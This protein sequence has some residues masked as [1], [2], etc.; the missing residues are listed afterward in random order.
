MRSMRFEDYVVARDDNGQQL[1]EQGILRR[2]GRAL[3]LGGRTTAQSAAAARKQ[4]NIE[5]GAENI[6]GMEKAKSAAAD[7][8]KEQ[9]AADFKTIKTAQDEITAIVDDIAMLP[10]TL[11]KQAEGRRDQAVEKIQQIA[12]AIGS[13]SY[14]PDT[15]RTAI[16]GIL[17][18]LLQKLNVYVQAVSQIAGNMKNAQKYADE[19]NASLTEI[20]KNLIKYYNDEIRELSGMA[21][22]KTK[23]KPISYTAQQ[24]IKS[25]TQ[26][27]AKSIFN[28]EPETQA[29][30]SR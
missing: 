20:S 22:V 14:V 26:G 4:R 5:T 24:F 2:I 28:R 1:D 16:A 25:P 9:K 3:G 15:D 8:T 6:R 18:V 17:Q 29:G 7:I 30:V 10:G 12:D 11:I 23:V 13:L 19:V 21:D 27:G